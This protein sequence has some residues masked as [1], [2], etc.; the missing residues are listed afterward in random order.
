MSLAPCRA[1]PAVG[2]RPLEG[3][4]FSS[5]ACYLITE[6]ILLILRG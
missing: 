3:Q 5:E 2:A 6:F 4:M 1:K